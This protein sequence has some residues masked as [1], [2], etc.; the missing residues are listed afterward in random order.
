MGFPNYPTYV[1]NRKRIQA[2]NRHC[3][4][5]DQGSLVVFIY[6]GTAPPAFPSFHWHSHLGKLLVFHYIEFRF[7]SCFPTWRS[8]WPPPFPWEA[9]N[10]RNDN[11]SV[12]SLRWQVIL[13]CPIPGLL[14]QGWI[15]LPI[16]LLQIMS[17]FGIQKYLV[18]NLL[19]VIQCIHFFLS[20]WTQRFLLKIISHFDHCCDAQT[21]PDR[22]S[23]RSLQRD[24]PFWHVP[25]LPPVF[26]VRDI[27]GSYPFS[28]PGLELSPFPRGS[29]S[30][31]VEN[32]I[33]KYEPIS[34][35]CLPF[36]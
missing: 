22:C 16:P 28:T 27:L 31:Q 5:R 19:C 21:V 3:L 35:P 15:T 23:E 17:P 36:H 34:E 9:K 32:G 24:V 4:E 6:S 26:W 14:H 20:V 2:R 10:D 11:C 29:A 7:V 8:V 33:C 13:T 1:L 25:G 30:F 18:S 12:I